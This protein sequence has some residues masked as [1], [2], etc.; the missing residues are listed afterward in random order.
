MSE[1]PVFLRRLR[2]AVDAIGLLSLNPGQPRAVSDL[3][4]EVGCDA[5]ALQTDLVA[6]YATDLRLGAGVEWSPPPLEFS[7]TDAG[8]DA[9]LDEVPLL[10]VHPSRLLVRVLGAEPL[11]ELGIALVTPGQAVALHTVA[12]RMALPEPEA[13]VLASALRKVDAAVRVS[14]QAIDDDPEPTDARLEVLRQAVVGHRRVR[15]RYAASWWKRESVRE[16]EPLVLQWIDGDWELDAGPVRGGD[17]RSFLIDHILEVDLLD[18]TFAVT[19]QMTQLLQAR[20]QLTTVRL[21]VPADR[22][23]VLPGM[24]SGLKVLRADGAEAQVD[25]TLR[26]PVRERLGVVLC[27]LGSDAFV[28]SPGHL[29]SCGETTARLL[30]RSWD[31]ST[32]SKDSA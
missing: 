29:I 9:E 7:S 25:L 32:S 20:R 19:P 3:A 4:A 8:V 23:W 16:V 21:V 13:A 14:E 27:A 1:L 15:L 28:V 17:L 18:D 24:V 30:L 2:H 11:S 31:L 6:F 10:T 22:L 12:E 5:S 26:E